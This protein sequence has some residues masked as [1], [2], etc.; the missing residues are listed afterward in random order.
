MYVYPP[1]VMYDQMTQFGWFSAAFFLLLIFLG[2]YAA[3]TAA[4]GKG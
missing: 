4:P 2:V 1:Q 3:A